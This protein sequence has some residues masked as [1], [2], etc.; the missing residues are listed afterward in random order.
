ME[1]CYALLY[2]FVVTGK[3][4]RLLDEAAWHTS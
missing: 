1:V 4:V 3:A 2:E